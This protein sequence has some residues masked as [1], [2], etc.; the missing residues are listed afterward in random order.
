MTYNPGYQHSRQS[1]I[2]NPSSYGGKPN[3]PHNPSVPQDIPRQGQYGPPKAT[4]QYYGTTPPQTY[5]TTPPMQYGVTPPGQYSTGQVYGTSP[6]Q[7]PQMYGTTPPQQQYLAPFPPQ[8]GYSTQPPAGYP[9]PQSAY[10]GS[11]QGRPRGGST[12]SYHSQ[13]SH[14]SSYS[15]HSRYDEKDS[16]RKNSRV[17]SPRPSFGDTMTLVWSSLKGAFDS[18]K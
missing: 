10:S 8:S 9:A 15:K 5:G 17:D 6:L 7:N 12:S 1:S 2:S 18:R 13:K 4:A 16:R 11:Q 3:L 14:R